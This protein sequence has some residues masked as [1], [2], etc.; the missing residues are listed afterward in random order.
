MVAFSGSWEYID[1]DTDI[2]EQYSPK[3]KEQNMCVISLIWGLRPC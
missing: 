3:A 1:K 2:F